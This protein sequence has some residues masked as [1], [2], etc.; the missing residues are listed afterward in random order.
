MR[1]ISKRRQAKNK[2]TTL[3]QNLKKKDTNKMYQRVEMNEIKI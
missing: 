2:Q 1:I 3:S